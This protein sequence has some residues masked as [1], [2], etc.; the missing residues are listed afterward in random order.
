MGSFPLAMQRQGGLS[1]NLD[2]QTAIALLLSLTSGCLLSACGQ[3][4]DESPAKGSA[5][6]F[7]SLITI[8]KYQ[9]NLT[10]DVAFVPEW[11]KGVDLSN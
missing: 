9:K 10:N 4:S 8:I 6:C 2:L 5:F 1:N 3:K 11:S 7:T